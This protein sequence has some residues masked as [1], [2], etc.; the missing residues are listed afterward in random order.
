MTLKD[1]LKPEPIFNIIPFGNIDYDGLEKNYNW[2]VIRCIDWKARNKIVKKLRPTEGILA[3]KNEDYDSNNIFVMSK[4]TKEE[5][6]NILEDIFGKDGLKELGTVSR[7]ERSEMVAHRVVQ[8]LLNSLNKK[9]LFM[10]TNAEGHYYMVI[11]RITTSDVPEPYYGQIL[12]M[13]I[14]AVSAPKSMSSFGDV[15][16]KY[17]LITMNNTIREAVNYDATKWKYPVFKLDSTGIHSGEPYSEGN[18]FIA[19]AVFHEKAHKD[20]LHWGKSKDESKLNLS[21]SVKVYEILERLKDRYGKYLGE[22]SFASCV[23]EFL[24]DDIKEIY[25]D[26]MIDHFKSREVSIYNCTGPEHKSTV[27]AFVKA[28]E[29]TYGFKVKRSPGPAI[30]GYNIPIIFDPDYYKKNE[31]KDPHN[32][33]LVGITQ[34]AVIDTIEEIMS[35]YGTKDKTYR[36]KL[37]KYEEKRKLWA[38]DKA[39]KGKKYPKLPPSPVIIPEVEAMFEQLFIKEDI[40]NDTVSFYHWSDQHYPGNWTFAEPIDHKEGRK[41]IL[42]GF[43]YITI[44]PEAKIIE[45]R[46]YRPA[47]PLAPSKLSRIDWDRITYAVINPDGMVNLVTVTGAS[48]IANGLAIK[49]M[50]DANNE[51]IKEY[52]ERT[53]DWSEED[54]EKD[55]PNK[56]QRAEGIATWDTKMKYM[57]GCIGVGYYKISEDRWIYYVGPQDNPNQTITNASWV[58][59]IEAVDGSKIF[60]EDLFPMM[61]VPF[62]RHGQNSVKPFPIKY[63]EEWFK[64]EQPNEQ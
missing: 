29:D 19:K 37:A 23:G 57:G 34:F 54:K 26:R 10:E 6:Q 22:F 4:I 24:R 46:F 16:I 38:S 31:Q 9:S 5:L 40:D 50:V 51:K 48:T 14:D 2:S 64:K 59:L 25:H 20:L 32:G 15:M 18:M 62:V 13:S 61:A 58:Y 55:K 60:F 42:D 41:R 21:R 28:T 53:K 30:N 7:M 35:D 44:S 12:V 43:A 8:L 17:K 11:E 45:K 39:N 47:D 27:D 3:I 56:P 36:T 33:P 63:L 1:K 49:K 52:E